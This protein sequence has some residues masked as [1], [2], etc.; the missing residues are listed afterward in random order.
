MDR[1]E[2]LKLSLFAGV[3]LAAGAQPA[4]AAVCEGD[5]T[6]SQF[7]PKKPA[8]AQAHVND[9][10]KYAKCPYC[11]MD[12]KE[13]HRARMLVQYSDDV[14]DGV[15]S[16]HCL[17]LSL[18]LIAM[19]IALEIISSKSLFIPIVWDGLHNAILTQKTHSQ[20]LYPQ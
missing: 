18:G 9:I 5:G 2:A 8:D 15:C 12:R 13:H 7:V 20:F 1:R 3:G 6:P 4:Q 17:S 16:I 11:G 14:S 10:E 19:T